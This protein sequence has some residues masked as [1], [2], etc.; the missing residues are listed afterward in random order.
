MC[1][2]LEMLCDYI[3]YGGHIFPPPGQ[4]DRQLNNVLQ[5]FCEFE[6]FCTKYSLVR[7]L[8]SCTYTVVD[9]PAQSAWLHCVWW[10]EHFM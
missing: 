3:L 7:P 1:K 4:A 6:G 8:T 9:D 2:L 10:P 5:L